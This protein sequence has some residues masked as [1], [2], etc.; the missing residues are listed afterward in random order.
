MYS[1]FVFTF[2][3]EKTLVVKRSTLLQSSYMVK[4]GAIQINRHQQGSNMLRI[5]TFSNPVQ[6]NTAQIIVLLQKQVK[7]LG[8]KSERF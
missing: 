3:E 2:K 7:Q 1:T 6:S 8:A 4:E 5:T